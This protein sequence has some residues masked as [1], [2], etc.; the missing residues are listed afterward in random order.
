[1]SLLSQLIDPGKVIFSDWHSAEASDP[2]FTTGA[3]FALTHGHAISIDWTVPT[4]MFFTTR[5]TQLHSIEVVFRPLLKQPNIRLRVENAYPG[6]R[7]TPARAVTL[8]SDGWN[9][10]L[11]FNKL[12]RQSAADYF[13]EIQT[14]VRAATSASPPN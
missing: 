6:F 14:A 11:P 12:Y 4:D 9:Q 8:E 3:M 10:A 13:L 5:Q 7:S 2:D 1:V